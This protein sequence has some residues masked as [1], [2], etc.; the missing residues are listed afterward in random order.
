[1][2]TRVWPRQHVRR[3]WEQA[4]TPRVGQGVRLLTLAVWLC[5]SIA[6]G[7]QAPASSDLPW[8][9]DVSS[10]DPIGLQRE[11]TELDRGAP[12]PRTPDERAFGPRPPAFSGRVGDVLV[13]PPMVRETAHRVRIE[14]HAG[15]ALVTTELHFTTTGSHASEVK[16][17]LP[18]PT[19][20]T[21]ASLRVCTSAGCREGLVT[22]PESHMSAYDDAVQ[23][24][25]PGNGLAVA[26]ARMQQ[27]ERGHFIQLRAAPVTRSEELVASVSWIVETPLRNHNVRLTIPARGVDER[28]APAEVRFSA[29]ALTGV[30]LAD[31]PW[32]EA[33]AILEAWRPIHVVGQLVRRATPHVEWIT[34]P[35]PEGSCARLWIAGPYAAPVVS[36]LAIALDASASMRGP[37]RG[38]VAPA[39]AALLSLLPPERPMDVVV[40]AASA[41]TLATETRA[42]RL[43]LGPLVNATQ[44]EDLGG[45]T[46]LTAAWAVLKDWRARARN[47]AARQLVVIGDGTLSKHQEAVFEEAARSGVS[48]SWINLADT[49]THPE[50]RARVEETGG[51]TLDAAQESDLAASGQRDTGP[52]EDLLSALLSRP[53]ATALVLPRL[54]NSAGMRINIGT[55]RSG[56]AAIWSGAVG[57]QAAVRINGRRVRASA[58][59]RH[60]DHAVSRSTQT[61]ALPL[62][63]SVVAAGAV[64]LEAVAPED[65]IRA[66]QDRP[67][68]ALKCDPRGPAQRLSGVSSNLDPVSLAE[69][70]ECRPPATAASDA[71]PASTPGSGMPSSPLLTM[72]R[73]RILPVARAC[74]RRDRAGRAEYE[75]RAVFELELSN[76]EVTDAN[77]TGEVPEP[78]RRCLI[79]AADHLEVP[80]FTGVVRAR[81]PLRTQSEPLPSEIELSSGVAADLDRLLDGGGGALHTPRAF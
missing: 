33:P 60:R 25:G 40:F 37:P 65:V 4:H 73:Q 47:S 67:G 30:S 29:P 71:I 52:L 57:P 41:R 28:A 7:Q 17:R 72:L 10:D 16:Y 27:D 36:D 44:A 79:E 12:P 66:G 34:T 6:S 26:H 45:G 64:Q 19:S 51:I 81:Y 18:V 48:I 69:P 42:E 35:C 21:L 39:L 74:F 70:R 56:N 77:V 9:T 46:H 49:P 5:A 43:A 1:M 13:A 50:L 38:R 68:P 8:A 59:G 14:W 63:L 20:A 78:L 53:T 3:E 75:L 76:Q 23:A 62:A 11:D 54:S 61:L 31:G 24:R 15:L 22:A 2:L 32:T 80:P 58:H 55:V